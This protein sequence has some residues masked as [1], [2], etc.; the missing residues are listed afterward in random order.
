MSHVV[1]VGAGQAGSSVVAK[2]RN[3]GFTGQ[4]TLIG[5][6]TAPPYQRPPLSKAYLL[7]DMALERL[8]LRPESF[9]DDN[10]ISLSVANTAP[11]CSA[12]LPL[13]AEPVI[14]TDALDVVNAPP[15]D[16]V[17]ELF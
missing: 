15:P 5:E 13:K 9:Y 16:P 2:L 12:V 3:G 4:I 17:F 14:V 7:G 10:D 1:V 11:P 6:E 8:Y